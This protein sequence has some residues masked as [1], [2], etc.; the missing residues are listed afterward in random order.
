MY[1]VYMFICVYMY[2]HMYPSVC[3]LQARAINPDKNASWAGPQV[4]KLTA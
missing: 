4:D 3:W 2:I 1:C